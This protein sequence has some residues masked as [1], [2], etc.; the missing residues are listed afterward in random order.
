MYEVVQ[1]PKLFRTKIFLSN[2]REV[3]G[4]RVFP[5][6]LDRLLKQR[7]GSTRSDMDL[8]REHQWGKD[9]WTMGYRVVQKLQHQNC[10]LFG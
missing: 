3:F 8:R 10:L 5:A 1:E 9:I 4:R 2:K 6:S 7:N